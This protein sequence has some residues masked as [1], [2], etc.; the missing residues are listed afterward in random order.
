[1]FLLFFYTFLPLM[2]LAIS[3]DAMIFH[4]FVDKSNKKVDP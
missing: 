2:M 3:C 4:L 1:M